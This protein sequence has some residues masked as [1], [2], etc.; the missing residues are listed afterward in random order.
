MERL[1]ASLLFFF[2]GFTPFTFAEFLPEVGFEQHSAVML[3]ITPTTGQ[4][5]NANR[6]ADTFYGY[7]EGEL[8]QKFIQNINQLPAEQVA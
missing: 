1:T 8:E 3:V 7:V 6:A 4:I 2:L 5:V